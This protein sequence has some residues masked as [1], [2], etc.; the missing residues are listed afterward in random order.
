MS[1]ILE[2]LMDEY[3]ERFGDMFPLMCVKGM[4]EEEIAAEIERCLRE[5]HEFEYEE[6]AYY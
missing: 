1:E 4:D 5:G 6:G 3:E 2:E